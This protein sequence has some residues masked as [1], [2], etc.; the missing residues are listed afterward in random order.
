MKSYSFCFCTW[1][2]P[3]K[4]RRPVQLRYFRIGAVQPGF[5][6]GWLLL[7]GTLLS[8]AF[9]DR[10]VLA[11]TSF[12]Q[13]T[14][15][16]VP[17]LDNG[18]VAWGD[19]NND[20]WVDF[21]ADGEL[22]LNNPNNP[23][24]QIFTQLGN[25]GKDGLFGDYDNDGY[26]DF[27]SYHEGNMWENQSGAG[28]TEVTMPGLTG[29]QDL[30]EYSR[31]A[32]W[33]DHNLDGFIDLY[34]SDYL[35]PGPPETF[36]SDATFVNN[37]GTSFTGTWTQQIDASV[38]PNT[39]RPGRGVTAADFD[40]DGDTDIYVSYYR[41][42]PNGLRISD[43]T[44][45]F[46]DDV[47]GSYGALGG[48]ANGHWSHT[49]GSAW[50]DFNN[51][52]E[53]DLFVGNFAHEAGFSGPAR[54]PESRFLRNQGSGNP[55]PNDDYTFDDQGQG[56]V[57]YQETYA[58]PVV[59]D[60]DND[61]D[62]DLFFTTINTTPPGSNNEFAVLY[63]NDGT[64]NFN[65]V[66]IT[67]EANL[68][69]LQN[70]YQAGF[71]DY[72][73]DGDLD[74]VVGGHLY[75]NNGNSNNWLKVKMV[76]DGQTI[77]RDAVGAQVRITSGNDTFTRQVEFGTGE[78]N[79]NDPTLH[80][81]LG[82]LTGTVDL[83]ILWPGGQTETVQNLAVN[84]TH[85]IAFLSTLD[86]YQWVRPTAG[87][88]WHTGGNWSTGLVPDSDEALALFDSSYG[89]PSQI[90]M[91]VPITVGG[92]EFD[93]LTSYTINGAS[94]STILTLDSYL[95]TASI[96]ATQGDHAL[97]VR[98]DILSDTVID[99]GSGASLT[100]NDPITLN[101]K[102][103]DFSTSAGTIHLHNI[104]VGGTTITAG[105][106]LGT[107]G[108]TG[109]GAD[110]VLT[111]S[112]TLAIDLGDSITD[113]FNVSADVTLDGWLDVTVEPGHIP[114]GSYTVLT[115]SGTLA[116]NGLMLHPSDTGAFTLDVDIISGVVSLI[117]LAGGIG[118]DFDD[119]NIVDGL[120]FL[121][122]QQ[123]FSIGS[124]A[125]QSEGDADG[126]G[127]VDAADL[128]E[129]E[130]QFGVPPTLVA[131]IVGGAAVPE[132]TALTLLLSAAM[133][134]LICGRSRLPVH[135]SFNNKRLQ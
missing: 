86:E 35:D 5:C 24:G 131:G 87:G 57:A 107:V 54:Q 76:G 7:L 48:T 99:V 74:L 112:S 6:V 21:A 96:T 98:L 95:Q 25:V 71:A 52:G 40:R 36:Q 119:N 16:V 110:L 105:G 88:S 58:S 104:V 3:G 70:T 32:A 85:T 109:I 79:Q 23:G 133:A 78:G 20:G 31:G 89:S 62:L 130:L 41:L 12:S 100:F 37:G 103:I 4:P 43:G 42:E 94:G 129:W 46:T 14:S 90:D 73:N 66:D 38:S 106:T 80:F 49:I 9:D 83:E 93:S 135:K 123:N 75:R 1:R 134:C 102:S 116:D 82:S 10:A 108:T 22:Y 55:D 121:I 17:G 59:G 84:Q 51:D 28:F 91:I 64:G 29:H 117:A 60:Y 47:T 68:T 19:I 127:T 77:S 45:L 115:A 8:G 69:G 132:P 97:D 67:D 44:T 111:G 92:L 63:S 122:W 26:L 11:Q 124:G 2:A 120:D 50:G 53:I 30:P 27:F 61:G 56:G 65:F 81:G 34:I 18:K 39:P 128:A 15:T 13:V 114:N 126:N 72:D 101:D 113:H 125:S 118:A 33:S